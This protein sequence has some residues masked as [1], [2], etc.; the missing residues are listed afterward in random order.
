M[1]TE[2]NDPSER[3]IADSEDL[4]ETACLEDHTDDWCIPGD[5]GD[6]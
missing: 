5:L 2:P 1:S 6:Q 3:E 4:P